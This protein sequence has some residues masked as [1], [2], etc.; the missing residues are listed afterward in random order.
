MK[1]IPT[2]EIYH[3]KRFLHELMT[4]EEA[5]DLNA[6]GDT[7]FEDATEALENSDYT[8]FIGYTDYECMHYDTEEE[9]TI[10]YVSNY[11]G[12]VD[13]IDGTVTVCLFCDEQLEGDDDDWYE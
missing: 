1:T 4:V 5:K 11:R 12:E 9:D 7:W 13:A 3:A 2:E 6:S 8:T 10:E